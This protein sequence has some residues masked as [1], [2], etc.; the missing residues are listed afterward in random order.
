MRVLNVFNTLSRSYYA[1]YYS[2]LVLFLTMA[3]SC[4]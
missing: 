2:A 4:S 1:Q 3:L